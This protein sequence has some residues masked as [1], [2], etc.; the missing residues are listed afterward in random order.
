M[1]TTKPLPSCRVC[2]IATGLNLEVREGRTPLGQRDGHDIT[3][4][5]CQDCQTLDTVTPGMAVRACLRV[6]KKPESEY[7]RFATVLEGLEIDATAVLYE[8]TGHPR[9]GPQS[10]AFA[11]VPKAVRD[12]LKHA[13]AETLQARVLAS[14][15]QPEPTP[16][17]PPADAPQGCLACGVA[18]AVQ[19][20]G[21]LHT[22]GLTRGPERVDGYVC[23]ECSVA[24]EQVGAVGMDFLERA[25]QKHTGIA[26]SPRNIRP[27]IAVDLPPQAQPFGWM[28]DVEEPPL[29]LDPVTFL[30]EQVG[31][32]QTEVASLRSEV[33]A[34]RR[35]PVP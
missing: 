28:K 7:L 30:M 8:I 24:L 13:Y 21:P 22:F 31:D 20:H 4:G 1:T 33:D 29:T 35:V 32:L 25:F 26:W 11:H 5:T 6:I 14:L 2:G 18:T 3:V 19:W 17:P 9:R 23:P 10:K 27:W 16:E 34:L 12:T 15:P